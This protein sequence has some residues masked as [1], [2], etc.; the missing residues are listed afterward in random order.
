MN[1]PA[2]ILQRRKASKLYSASGKDRLS[3]AVRSS[4][5]LVHQKVRSCHLHGVMPL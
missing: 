2:Q 5:Y 4:S 1:L 3:A